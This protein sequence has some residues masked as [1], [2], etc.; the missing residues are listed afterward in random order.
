MKC[1]K[2]VSSYS[3]LKNLTMKKLITT[4]LLN[5]TIC[6]AVLAQAELS[7][8]ATV[9]D[10]GIIEQGEDTHIEFVITNSGTEPL[11][12]KD[13]HPGCGCTTPYW[14][15]EPILPGDTT[16]VAVTYDSKRLGVINKTVTISSNSSNDTVILRLKGE[17]VVQDTEIPLINE[18]FIPVADQ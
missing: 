10:Y 11:V 12:L 4:F 13:V 1:S 15:K 7:I 3:E 18:E 5:L 17:V 9:H 8:N 2:R 16:I 14:S 6:A